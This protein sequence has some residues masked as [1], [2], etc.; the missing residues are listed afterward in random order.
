[1]KAL[2][3]ALIWILG[4]RSGVGARGRGAYQGTRQDSRERQW[5]GGGSLRP[6]GRQGSTACNHYSR[7][8]EGGIGAARDGKIIAKHGY[9]VLQL[10]YFDA[11]GLPKDLGL[12][13]LEYFKTAIDWLRS[14]ESINRTVS[15]SLGIYRRKVADGGVALSRNQ[16]G[17]GHDAYK[18][19]PVS[20]ILKAGEPPSTFT[21]DESPYHFCRMGILSSIYNLYAKGL[22]ALEQHHDDHSR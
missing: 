3:V 17:G 11:P 15:A 19:V 8:L 1:M 4:L 10:A 5:T 9:A 21:L 16:S 22:L 18:A 12:I 2:A 7:R 6:R 13:P 14:Q 20:S